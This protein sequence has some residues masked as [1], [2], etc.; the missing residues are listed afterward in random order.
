MITI[1]EI[2]SLLKTKKIKW[3]GH[4]LKRMHQRG[5]L[6]KEI[7]D[8]LSNGEII[9]YYPDDYP[10]PSCLLLGCSDNLRAIHVVCAIGQEHLWLITAYQPDEKE[11][12]EDLKSRKGR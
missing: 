11:W 4:I 6:V 3:S 12:S 1:E 2:K 10:Y 8:C 9:E 7:M 5:I